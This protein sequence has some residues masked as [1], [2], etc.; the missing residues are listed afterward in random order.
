MKPFFLHSNKLRKKWSPG[1]SN[2]IRN[3][4]TVSIF[5]TCIHHNLK[6]MLCICPYL[7][8]FKMFAQPTTFGWFYFNQKPWSIL[9]GHQE[10]NLTFILCAK[11]IERVLAKPLIL[12]PSQDYYP[13]VRGIVGTITRYA[14]QC[15]PY[16]CINNM[17]KGH[18]KQQQSSFATF[19]SNSVD[20]NRNDVQRTKKIAELFTLRESRGYRIFFVGKSSA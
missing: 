16:S 8:I 15:S 17:A 4:K 12:P 6:C 13:E 7:K 18:E 10:I 1:N 9:F 5:K 19:S 3:I 14:V 11:E 2:W 20:S